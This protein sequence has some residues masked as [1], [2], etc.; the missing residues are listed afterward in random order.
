MH[1]TWLRESGQTQTG[2]ALQKEALA[3][4]LEIHRAELRRNRETPKT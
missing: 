3:E 1:A 4:L 2:A